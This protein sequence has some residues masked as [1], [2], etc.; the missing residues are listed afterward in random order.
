MERIVAV[1]V[2][3]VV[4]VMAVPHGGLF[5]PTGLK[6]IHTDY[7]V[8]EFW[9]K[10]NYIE[11]RNATLSLRVVFNAS[12]IPER[13]HAKFSAETDSFPHVHEAL[14]LPIQNGFIMYT[15]EFDGRCYHET[16]S[17]DYFFPKYCATIGCTNWTMSPNTDEYV[18][19]LQSSSTTALYEMSVATSAV[20]VGEV[21]NVQTIV[22]IS[23]EVSEVLVNP[24]YTEDQSFYNILLI[25]TYASPTIPPSAWKVPTNCSA[26]RSGNLKKPSARAKGRK[27]NSFLRSLLKRY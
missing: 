8:Y 26:L 9:L 14:F 23:D 21:T 4:V 17:K 18:T 6:L 27:R 15:T 22:R 11:K 2:I 5:P 20:V 24:G 7:Y 25:A 12:G 19:W 16:F 10:D 13:F 1:L 3:C